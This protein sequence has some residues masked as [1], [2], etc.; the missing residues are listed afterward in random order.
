M[1]RLVFRPANVVDIPEII[2]FAAA[3]HAES[4]I[5]LPP[6]NPEAAAE[7]CLRLIDSEGGF[8]YVAD[9]GE[10][11]VGF[12]WA[13]TDRPWYGDQL[14]VIEDILFVAPEYRGSRCAIQLIGGLLAWAKSI[15]AE[16]VISGVST[17]N[18][19]AARLYRAFGF[20]D[21]GVNFYRAP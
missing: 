16:R 3:I 18:M 12:I 14:T 6:L 8:V 11:I 19:A 9:D 20:M 17:G 2:G 13:H 7:Y 4:A 5:T 15:N 1:R 21:A 10:K